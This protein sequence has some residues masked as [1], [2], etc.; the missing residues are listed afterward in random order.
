MGLRN[1]TGL[2]NFYSLFLPIAPA[3]KALESE[4]L[5]SSIFSI[6]LWISYP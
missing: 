2:A 5:E 3:S 4:M 6:Y 1:T